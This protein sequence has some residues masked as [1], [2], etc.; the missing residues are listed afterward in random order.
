MST[1]AQRLQR[2]DAERFVGRDRELA[3]FDSLFTD[4]PPAQVVHVHGA[5]GIGKSTLLREVARHAVGRGWQPHVIEGREVGPVPGDIEAAVSGARSEERPLLL[6]D[7]YERMSAVDAWLRGRLLPSLP[8]RAI[9]ILAGRR[10]PEP[11]WFRDGWERLTVEL[12]LAPFG[13]AEGL[14]LLHA[15]GLTDDELGRR[16][17]AWA[18]GSPLALSL[19]AD[20]ARREG[21]DWDHER[22]HEQ[23]NLVQA[24]LQRLA[25]T[26][27]DRGNLEVAAVAAIV[28]SC[29]RELLADVLPE[30]DPDAAYAWLQSL[31]FSERVGDGVALHELVR[32]AIT[33]DLRASRPERDGELRCRIADHHY[34]R[35]RHVGTRVLVD[36]VDLVRNPTIRWGFGADGS[37]THRPDLWRA[38]DL[39]AARALFERHRHGAAWW[40]AT[41]R[42]LVEAPD[43]AVTVRDAHDDLV[44]LAIAVTPDNAP[45]VAEADVRL[46]SWLRHARE[47]HAGDE[48]LIWRD[49][50]DFA[51]NGDPASPVPSILNTAAILRSGLRNPRWSYIPI[52]PTHEAAVAFA[53]AVGTTHLAH[54]DVEHE[55]GVTQC[56][57][58]DHGDE[59]IL[60]G[61]RAAVYDEVGLPGGSP[62][63]APVDGEAIRHALRN[64]HRPL[65][66]AAN[67]LAH[68]HT[69]EER[70]ASVRA[71]LDDAVAHAFGASAD[72]R[73]L[74]AVIERGYLNPVG[75]HEQAA[76]ALHVS[77]ATYFRRL[78]VASQ[79]VCDYLV[80]KHGG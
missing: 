21:A 67:P 72:E 64:A 63:T 27:L 53:Q 49:S 32:Q 55:G 35:G 4:D 19:A 14:A 74:R 79:R 57:R 54:L 77:R 5:G 45:P 17:V 16:I 23:P 50:I 66:L 15:H 71:A 2:R 1:L 26:E 29:N 38:D 42:L 60:G 7:T 8:G 12:S 69:P 18:D 75:S 6:F 80:A 61:I 70:A 22:I 9:I 28:R 30:V 65:E 43:R 78:R 44:G 52:D 34:R 36:L 31:S 10:P 33:A 59:G 46:G 13:A 41:E 24:I 25:R 47:T 48:V 3:F 56:H 58:V 20:A 68:G 40:K 62:A 11:G 39:D 73:L 51:A 76:D 37:T